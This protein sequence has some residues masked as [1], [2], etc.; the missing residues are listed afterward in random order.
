[1]DIAVKL[2]LVAALVMMGY[3]ISEFVTSY[4]TICA[5]TEEFKKMMAETQEGVVRRSNLLLSLFLSTVFTCLTYWSG[6][7][8]WITA[9]V[10]LKLLFTLCCSDLTLVHVLRVGDLTKKFYMLTK[11]DALFNAA[12]G[13]GIALIVVL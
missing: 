6:L 12:V 13:L 2:T 3:N 10:A 1:M 4:E 7:A 11:V 8:L 5:K 9:V